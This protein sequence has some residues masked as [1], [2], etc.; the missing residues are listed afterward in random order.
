MGMYQK[1]HKAEFRDLFVAMLLMMFNGFDDFDPDSAFCPSHQRLRRS[2]E[3][4]VRA[5][6][7]GGASGTRSRL[8]SEH[9][10]VTR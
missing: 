3:S 7:T 6:G 10:N 9:V 4:D 5:A 1:N 2:D 8:S